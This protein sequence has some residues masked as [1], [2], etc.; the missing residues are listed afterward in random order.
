M[1]I[2]QDQVIGQ[3]YVTVKEKLTTEDHTLLMQLNF[4]LP[5]SRLVKQIA[6]EFQAGEGYS[7]VPTGTDVCPTGHTLSVG[8]I[9]AAPRA[10]EL[11]ADGGGA[12]DNGLSLYENGVLENVTVE[13]HLRS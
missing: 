3:K 5:L 2:Y 9:E 12:L 7:R 6:M 1:P 10:Y 4:D 8:P 11:R 13:L